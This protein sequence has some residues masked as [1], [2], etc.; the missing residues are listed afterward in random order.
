M[1]A[2][3]AVRVADMLDTQLMRVADDTLTPAQLINA[4]ADFVTEARKYSARL[5]AAHQS[6]LPEGMDE[7]L[8]LA[9]LIER[10]HTD[11][12]PKPLAVDLARH[13]LD[14]GVRL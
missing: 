11:T 13:L 2:D 1:D 7:V 9:A 6:P 8:R 4:M 3:T 5:R 14:H 10:G 12:N